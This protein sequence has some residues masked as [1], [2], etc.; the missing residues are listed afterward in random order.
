M[1]EENLVQSVNRALAILEALQAAGEGLGVTE[2]GTRVGLHKSTVYRL[3][4]TLAR[5]GY[6]EQ[7]PATERYS[8]GLKLVELGTAVLERLELR[9]LARPYLKRLMEASQEVAHLVVLQDG[10]VV[11]IDKVECPGPVKMYSQLGRRAPAHA[12]AV[13]K[14]LLAFLPKAQVDAILA[15]GLPRLTPHT[16]TDPERLRRELR[17]IRER[18]YALDNEENELGIRCVAG[19]IFNHTGQVVAAFSISGLALRLLP[20]KLEELGGL[21]RETSRE[22]S[23]RLGYQ[24]AATG[25][26]C[27]L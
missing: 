18:G 8:L 19:P 6:V 10:E 27:A 20:A 4:A 22:I 1:K 23:A 15:R 26:P 9:D 14:V 2:I 13:G 25:V 5:H 17:L 11:Y 7:D 24:P 3:L 12:T 21:V 16:I